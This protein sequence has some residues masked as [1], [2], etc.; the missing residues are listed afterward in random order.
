MARDDFSASIKNSLKMRAAFICSNP[1]CKKLTIAPSENDETKVNYIAKAAHITAAAEGGPRYDSSLSPE[2]RSS[3]NNAIFLCSNCADLIDKNDGLDYPSLLIKKWKEDHENWIRNNLN[4]QF[5]NSDTLIN[6]TS[7][8]QTGGITAGVINVGKPKRVFNE[9]QKSQ[10]IKLIE[11]N[12]DKF[13]NINISAQMGCTECYEF[14]QQIQ[15]F[16]ES[17]DYTSNLGTIQLSKPLKP[18]E[19]T[20]SK[21]PPSTR[22]ANFNILIGNQE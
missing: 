16:L 18:I 11:E 15:S 19:I 20:I 21:F 6:V 14:G 10:L 3:I 7:I 9:P 4:K 12:K 8:N 1:D 22:A 2:E 13:E 17:K 5:K